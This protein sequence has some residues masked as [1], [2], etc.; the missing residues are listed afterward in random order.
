MDPIGLADVGSGC[1]VWHPL[2]LKV[3]SIQGGQLR[4]RSANC[5][6]FGE[7]YVPNETGC[8]GK[9][10]TQLQLDAGGV[11]KKLAKIAVAVATVY[12]LPLL[13]P[14]HENVDWFFFFGDLILQQ[15]HRSPEI[16]WKVV[17][18]VSFDRRVMQKPSMASSWLVFTFLLNNHKL[19]L[20]FVMMQSL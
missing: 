7:F 3:I 20:S 2:P 4:F 16:K 14:E 8:G 5:L 15:Q 12:W 17:A 6:G 18:P 1:V 11:E 19:E 9:P 13:N 10:K